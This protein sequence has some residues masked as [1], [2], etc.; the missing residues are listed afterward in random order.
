MKKVLSSILIVTMCAFLCLGCGEDE[1]NKPADS[2]SGNESV[3][4]VAG[5]TIGT[6][7]YLAFAKEIETN[8][9]VEAVAN[10]LCE[11][12]VF[13]EIVTGTLLVEEGYLN[14]FDAEITG[15]SKGAMFAPM[16]GTIPF[17]G[18]V[19]E[20]DNP[21]ELIKTL[22]EHAELNWNICTVADEMVVKSVGNFVY[23]VM[24]PKSFE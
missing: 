14:G 15:F 10:A 5:G 22:T 23:F 6:D 17:V 19:F 9:D 4:E 8:Q 16:I 18:Y 24:A 2:T 3:E 13:G 7:L 21:D 20:T 12:E 1:S 11:N